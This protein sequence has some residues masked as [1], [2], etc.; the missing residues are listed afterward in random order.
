MNIFETE[1]DRYERWFENHPGTY[2]SEIAAVQA[3]LENVSPQ[4]RG[5]EIGMGTGRFS[6]PFGITEGVEPA[7]AMRRIAEQHGLHVL[8]AKAEALPYEDCTFDFALM[9]TTI[10]FVDDPLKACREAWRVLK[11]GGWL[12]I[13]L[14][15]SDSD[16]G[17]HYEAHREESP[18]YRTARFFSITELSGIIRKAGFKNLRY[19]QTLFQSPEAPETKEPVKE[20]F[21]EGGFVVISGEKDKEREGTS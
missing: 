1:V 8:D 12:I 21:G 7:V 13:G 6:T 15:D 3:A 17:Q 2:Q 10:C 20:G 11:P 16:L 19:H 5:L 9:V 18:F 14:V 4:G